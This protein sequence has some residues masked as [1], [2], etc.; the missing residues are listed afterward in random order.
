MA[1]NEELKTFIPSEQYV[2]LYSD[3]TEKVMQ[4]KYGDLSKFE[5]FINNSTSYNEKGQDIFNKISDEITEIL[6]KCGIF[7]VADQL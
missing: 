4:E 3:L 6:G 7:N 1:T 2:E 5:V